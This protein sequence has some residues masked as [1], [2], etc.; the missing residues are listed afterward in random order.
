MAVKQKGT[1]ERQE[2]A[3]QEQTPSTAPDASAPDT[4]AT[5]ENQEQTQAQ[6]QQGQATGTAQEQKPSPEST[7]SQALTQQITQA[8]Q[9][10]LSEFQQQVTQTLGQQAEAMLKDGHGG[11]ATQPSTQATQE[12]QPAQPTATP[13]AGQKSS[14]PIAQLAQ[15][16]QSA[17]AEA[18][19]PA[20]KAIERDGKEWL[21]IMLTAGLTM[22]LG[23]T[24]RA[25][26]QQRAEQGL[27]TLTQKAFEAAPDSLN[28]QEAK[29]RTEGALQIFLQQS[30]DNVFSEGTRA[31]LQQEGQAAIQESL[32]GDFGDALKNVGHILQALAEALLTVLR[33]QWQTLLRLALALALLSIASALEAS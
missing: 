3:Q 24:M 16:P 27:H 11:Q 4:Q 14:G 8:I 22:L 28:N 17:V 12:S 26:I 15:V 2:A 20:L 1:K 29:T 21:Q 6:T 7:F 25:T 13:E 9:P 31:R 23:D 30:L 19:R 33:Q 18:V 10:V 5:A 32:R